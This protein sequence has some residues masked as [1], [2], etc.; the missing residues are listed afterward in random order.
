M[1]G[2][3]SSID[4]AAKTIEIDTDDGSEGVFQVLTKS[5]VSFDFNKDLRAD[6]TP[7]DSFTKKGDEVIVFYFGGS[8]LPRTAI[9]LQDLGP[10]PLEKKSGTVVKFDKHGHLVTIMTPSGAKEP[11]HIEAK[12]VA[13]TSVG[14]V[15]ASKFDPEKGDQIQVIATTA[16]GNNT[17]LFIHAD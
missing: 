11:F 13:E 8:Y 12:T 14:A 7:A 9:A 16:N 17:A 15:P 5:N 2:T 6:A 4:P 10:G 3:V 1:S